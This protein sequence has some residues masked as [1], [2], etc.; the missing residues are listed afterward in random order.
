MFISIFTTDL[1]SFPIP[2]PNVQAYF[3]FNDFT[4][5][6]GPGFPPHFEPVLYVTNNGRQPRMLGRY[7]ASCKVGPRKFLFGFARVYVNEG[8]R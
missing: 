6:W 8:V 1:G 7:I 5:F 2:D 3:E 4:L